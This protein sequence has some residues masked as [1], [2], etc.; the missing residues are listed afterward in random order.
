MIFK[1][2]LFKNHE[3]TVKSKVHKAKYEHI[4]FVCEAKLLKLAECEAVFIVELRD[5]PYM[6]QASYV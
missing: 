2:I 6:W 1:Q 3:L 4:K 5:V